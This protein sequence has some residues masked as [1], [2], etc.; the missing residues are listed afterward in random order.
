MTTKLFHVAA[1]IK[2]S[3]PER[4]GRDTPI[5]IWDKQEIQHRAFILNSLHNGSTCIVHENKDFTQQHGICGMSCML[6]L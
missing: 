3:C 5:I 2:L 6:V 4:S 1:N